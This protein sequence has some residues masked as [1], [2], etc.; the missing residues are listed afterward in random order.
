[1]GAPPAAAPPAG[2]PIQPQMPPQ[3]APGPIQP[4]MPPQ[5]APAGMAPQGAPAMQ[6]GQFTPSGDPLAGLAAKVPGSKPGTLFGIPLSTLRDQK[7]EQKALLFMG[8]LV[9]IGIFIPYSTDPTRFSWD[10]KAK[11]TPLIWPI[12]AAACYLLVALSPKA[13]RENVPPVVMKWIPFGVSLVSIGI[14]GFGFVYVAKLQLA[15]SGADVGLPTNMILFLWGYPILCFGLLA[16]LANPDDQIARIV[17]G[18]GVA[19]ILPFAIEYITDVA[20]KFKGQKALEVI[21]QLCQFVVILVA[22][23]C[24]VFV[25]KPST[26]PALRSVD[27]FAPLFTAILLG[28]LLVQIALLVLAWLVHDKGGAVGDLL[29]G[30]HMFVGTFAYFGILMLTAPE[31]YDSLME[32]FSGHK[33]TVMGGTVPQGPYAQAPQAMQQPGAP[34]PPVQPAQPGM[35]AGPVQPAQPGQPAPAPGRIQPQMPPQ[36]PGGPPP[37]AG[38]PGGGGGWPPQGGGQQQ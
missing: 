30:A 38:P 22:L 31:A 4:Q 26:V 9:A 19:L 21:H 23:A 37:P 33:A 36:G 13:V 24:A 15:A 34:A 12:I 20:F 25:V 2:G 18:V 32:I 17:I 14:V 27:A 6:P 7:F 29:R 35:P 11:F 3:G 16:R 8:V 1:M 10:A 5:G 28:W